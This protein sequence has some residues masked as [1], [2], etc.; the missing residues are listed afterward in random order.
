M[1]Q[2]FIIQ[3]ARRALLVELLQSLAAFALMDRRAED[4]FV[5][6]NMPDQAPFSMD[7]EIVNDGFLSVRS[8]SYFCFL[9]AFVESASAIATLVVTDA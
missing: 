7:F 5:F 3:G 1:Q 6:T 9:G 8:G 2:K 4:F